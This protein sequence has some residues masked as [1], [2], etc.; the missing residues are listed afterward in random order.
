MYCM[1]GSIRQN[2]EG[3]AWGTKQKTGRTLRN[4]RWGFCFVGILLQWMVLV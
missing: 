2:N 3:L 4:E 1:I